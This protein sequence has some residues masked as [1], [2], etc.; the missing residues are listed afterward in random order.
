M[1]PPF[2]SFAELA[3]ARVSVRGYRSD[4][5]PNELV[6]RVLDAARMAPS[7]ANR[8][9]WRVIVTR[10]PGVRAAVY[11]AY[12]RDWLMQAPVFLTVC[13]DPGR[14]WTRA[15]DGWNA[16]D[17]DGAILMT[18]IALAAADA[19]LGTCWI[20]A[21]DPDTLRAALRVPPPIRP[22]AL[23]P[24]GYPSDPGRPKRRE[25][26]SDIVSDDTWRP[27]RGRGD[28]NG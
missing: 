14:A 9:P 21:F 13:V 17:T 1:Y 18:H 8:Q 5:V 23:T 26:L 20:A 11:A 25:A 4:P 24:L 16:A 3:A 15:A 19:G 28:R 7:A 6:E 10:D 2:S 12:P 22:Y 27:P